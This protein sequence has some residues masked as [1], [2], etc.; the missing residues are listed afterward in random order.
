MVILI[1]LKL[2]DLDHKQTYI[3]LTFE[4][5]GVFQSKTHRKWAKKESSKLLFS[6]LIEI[7]GEIQNDLPSR[8]DH[9][10]WIKIF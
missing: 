2:V 1:H 8:V 3:D 10:D 7:F 4:A 9:F 6:F 5:F